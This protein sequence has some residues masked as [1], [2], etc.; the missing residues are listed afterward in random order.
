MSQAEVIIHYKEQQDRLREA[1]PTAGVRQAEVNHLK[2]AGRSVG[3]GSAI[4]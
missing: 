1:L 2:G 3:R 4:I